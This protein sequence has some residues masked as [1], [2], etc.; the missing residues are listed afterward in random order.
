M[1]LLPD[2][3]LRSNLDADGFLPIAM[4]AAFPKVKAALKEFNLSTQSFFLCVN[5]GPAPAHSL[6]LPPPLGPTRT[7]GAE[8]C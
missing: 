6:P 5:G 3:F 7:W 8:E 2:V 1:F 4:V